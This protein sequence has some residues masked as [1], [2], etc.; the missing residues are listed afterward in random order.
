MQKARFTTLRKTSITDSLTPTQLGK[1]RS[2]LD[3]AIVEKWKED[4]M[5]DRKRAKASAKKT[6]KLH[7]TV[8]VFMCLMAGFV[9]IK[10][11]SALSI[12]SSF[13]EQT[14]IIDTTGVVNKA[15]GGSKGSVLGE[16]I[17]NNI[18][19]IVNGKEVTP[20]F[21]EA[22]QKYKDNKKKS[23]KLG[24]VE[25]SYSEGEFAKIANAFSS[26]SYIYTIYK[27][28]HSITG[29][30]RASLIIVII[31]SVLLNLF[32]T[33]FVFNVL[34]AVMS[35]IFLEA[36]IYEKIPVKNFFYLIRNRKW[37]KAGWILLVKEFY[38]T[39]W[40]LTVIGGVIKYYS[41]FLVPYIA[42]ENPNLSANEVITMSRK[43]MKGHKWECFK[44]EISFIGWKLLGAIS[45]GIVEVLW[46]SPYEE[47]TIAEYYSALR[48]GALAGEKRSEIFIDRYLFEKAPRDALVRTYSDIDDLKKE[49]EA[50]TDHYTGVR[51]FFANVFGIVPMYSERTEAI[52]RNEINKIKVSQSGDE[53]E[54]RAYPERLAPTP[55]HEKKHDRLSTIFYTRSYSI[56]SLILMFFIGCFIGWAWEVIYKYIEI[57]KFVNRGV[58]HGPWLP[59]YG[60]GAVMILVALKKFRAKPVI[61]FFTAI[62]LCGFVEYYTAVILE[63]THNGQKWW[64]YSGYFLNINGRVCAEGLMIFGIG[65]VAFVYFA[66]P[67]IDNHLRKLSGKLTAA[68]CAVLIAFF[69]ADMIYSRIHPNV[70]TGITDYNTS[71]AVSEESSSQTTS[72]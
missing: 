39:L 11:S 46:V 54:G 31:A 60:S 64:D 62:V 27:G 13:S 5:F 22:K 24:S 69:A 58:M 57:G 53:L 67:M 15:A 49:T 40:S 52:D 61:E 6:V 66:A 30:D 34:S 10:Y 29:S 72:K 1:R 68:V 55:V 47:A 51:A 14:D 36:R 42:A 25:V 41:Y 17:G 37:L 56:G 9:G 43:L 2:F 23:M 16:L 19:I 18:D 26:G 44:L 33:Y 20:N 28:V 7:Y 3:R 50:F 65:G 59:I 35:R 38:F 45:F 21:D 8:L 63:A 48:S 70:G 71:S 4:M 32:I 12:I